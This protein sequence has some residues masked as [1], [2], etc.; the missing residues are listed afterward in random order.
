MKVLLLNPPSHGDEKFVR[1]GRC[2]QRGGAWTAVWSPVSLATTA[3]V[4]QQEGHEVRLFDC[5]VTDM[6]RAGLQDAVSHFQPD[7]V[8]L[9]SSTPSIRWDLTTAEVVA[10]ILPDVFTVAFGIH[11]SALPFESL[12]LSRRLDAVIIAEP[13]YAVR[14]LAAALEG[15]MLRSERVSAAMKVSGLAVK[16][17]NRLRRTEARA[18]IADLNELPFPAWELINPAHYTLPFTGEPFLLVATGRGCPHRC[19]F[20]AAHAYYGKKLRL[21]KASLVVD[22]IERNMKQFGVRNFLFWTEAFTMRNDYALQVCAEIMHRKLDVAWVCNS[23][24]DDVTPELLAQMKKA[25]CTMV[26]YG[27]ESANPEVLKAVEKGITLAQIRQAVRWTREAG[28]E[29]TGHLMVGFPGEDQ[30]AVRR[31]ADLA[32]SLDLDFAQFYSVVPFPGSVLFEQSKAAGT[33]VNWDFAMFEQN[34]GVLHTGHLTPQQVMT[35]RGRAYRNFYFRPIT[36]WRTVKRLRN[37]ASWI[38]FAGM[39]K[40]FLTWI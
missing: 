10:E 7:I 15:T 9:N 13:E 27:I 35:E 17:E 12:M 19:T 22:E 40:D 32:V 38:R 2:M 8:V 5:V 23:R 31:T 30:S 21:R 4:L 25:G 24:V 20:C 29:V 36:V 34:Y 16:E 39:V 33:I 1:E 18:A 6:D 3:A 11:V 14:D 26:G 37:P 28:I